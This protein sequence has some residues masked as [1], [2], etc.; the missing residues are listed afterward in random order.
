MAQIEDVLKALRAAD[1]AGNTEDAARL[2]QLAQ[3]MRS[4][5]AVPALA[6]PKESAVPVEPVAPGAQR[7]PANPDQM[8]PVPSIP[9][10]ADALARAMSE[11]PITPLDGRIGL[12]TDGGA[13]WAREEAAKRA[14]AETAPPMS[15]PKPPVAPTA[16]PLAANPMRGPV[17]EELGRSNPGSLS[18]QAAAA[19]I[20][21]EAMDPTTKSTF[22][23]T[24]Q[25]YTPTGEAILSELGNSWSRI[26]RGFL[27]NRLA[28]AE[29]GIAAGVTDIGR[30]KD[31]ATDPVAALTAVQN[32][33]AEAEL[34]FQGTADPVE[35]Q[36]ILAEIR[37][38]GQEEDRL[39]T[40]VTVP[41]MAGR[42]VETNQGQLEWNQRRRAETQAKIDDLE[43]AMTPVNPAPGL[44]Q[45]LVSGIA[46]VGDMAPGM[47]ATLATRNPLPMLTYL[48]AYSRG[49]T[50]VDKRAEG[51]DSGKAVTAANL[52]AV[53]EAVPELLPLHVILKE[54]GG[55]LSKIVGGA[56]TEAASEVLT[57][58]LQQLVDMGV[59][60]ESMTWA[61]AQQ[62]MIDSGMA[63]GVMGALMGGGGA[64]AES[65]RDTVAS[66]RAKKG[67]PADPTATGPAPA[68]KAQDAPPA[69]P[70][71]SLT[72]NMRADAP[73]EADVAPVTPG[74]DAPVSTPP[75]PLQPE[76]DR[77]QTGVGSEL[78]GATAAPKARPDAPA[79]GAT[80]SATD[81]EA[82]PDRYEIMDEIEGVGPGA[83]P[84]GRRVARDRETGAFLVVDEIPAGPTAGDPPG[85]S[86]PAG[87]SSQVAPSVVAG[88]AGGAPAD[89]DPL[90]PESQIAAAMAPETAPPERPANQ[91][92]NVEFIDSRGVAQIGTEPGVMQYKA[93]GDAE[94]VTDRLRGVTEW[95]PERAGMSIVYEYADGRRVI[96]DGHQRLGLAKRLAGEG[97]QV[98]MPA[99]ILRQR[100]GITPE[101]ARVTAALKN[102]AE[103]SGTAVDAA[104]VLRGSNQTAE[105]MGLP[106]NSAIVRDA[107]GMRNL[108]D[109]A[110]GMVV[111]GVSSERDGGIVGRI[112]QNKEAQANI[113]ALLNR[114]KPSN[115]F[116]AESIARQAAADVVTETQD[117]LFGPEMDTRNLY[118]ERAKILDG[119]A[120]LNRDE[121]RAFGTVVQNA[122]RLQ[123]AGNVLD[124]ASNQSRM[125]SASAMRDYLTKEA[126]TRGPIS[127]ALT[128]AARALSG[129]A[130][131]GEATRQF[132]AAVERGLGSGGQDSPVRN[133]GGRQTE[134]LG[135]KG[136]KPESL[137][138]EEQI[139]AAIAPPKSS[140]NPKQAR[141]EA[142]AAVKG[143]QSKIRTSAPQGDPG[144]LFDDQGDLLGVARFQRQPDLVQDEDATPAYAVRDRIPEEG[145]LGGSNLA[146]ADDQQELND[147]NK[148]SGR[149]PLYDRQEQVAAAL[150]Y[151]PSGSA[152]VR[153]ADEATGRIVKLLPRLRAEL[154][155]LDL[156]RVR[157]GVETGVDWQG[158]FAITGDGAME[159][160]IGAS[161]DPM[162]TLHH[163]VIHA[164]RM[165]DLFTPAEWKVLE[166]A[167]ETW[168]EKHDIAARY[169]DLSHAEQ[170][171]EAIA[172]EFSE[173]LAAKKAPRGSLLIQAF[174]KIARV[175]RAIANV[176]RGAGFHS[177]EDIFGRVLAGE[178]GARAGTAG[179]GG[180][181]L[182]DVAAYQK[183]QGIGASLDAEMDPVAVDASSI[184][185]GTEKATARDAVAR[186][187]GKTLATADGTAVRI[188]KNTQGK[189]GAFPKGDWRA[190]AAVA[191]AL[192]RIITAARVF[193]TSQDE[194]GR[195]VG[196]K[197]AAAVA[198]IDGE[199]VVVRLS[200]MHD[201]SRPDQS[202]AYDLQG[203]EIERLPASNAGAEGTS[204]DPLPGNRVITLGEAVAAIKRG[205]RRF[206]RPRI[207]SRQARAHMSTAMGGEAA[208]VPDRRI[209]EELSSV[210]ASVWNRIGG[211]AGAVS[212]T[213]DRARVGLQDR[214]LPIMRAQEVLERANGKPLPLDQRA[215]LAETTFSGKAGRH[216]FEIDEEFTKP[217]INLIAKTEGLN[218]EIV[219][220]WLYARHAIE[221][222]ARIASINPKMPDG[223][224]G[225]TNAEAQQI[226][227]DSKKGPQ[228]DVLDAIGEKIDQL[229]ERMLKLRENAGLITAEEAATWRNSYA[230]Y[231]PLKGFSE[232]EH[233]DAA[234]DVSGAG[235]RFI[236]RGDESRRALGRRSEAFNPLQAALTQA[237]EVAIR[238]EKNRVAQSVYELA[239]ANPSPALWE[240]KKPA[241]KRY[242]N[243]T[244]GMVE[245]R[246]ENPISFN[247][248]PN[249]MAAKV[250]GEEVRIIFHDPRLA[251]AVIGLGA[252]QWQGIVKTI[253]PFARLFSMVNTGLSPAFVIKNAIR[254][255]TT[256][257]LNMAALHE[258]KAAGF[259][260]TKTQRAKIMLAMAKNWRKALL[261]TFRGQGYRFDTKWS[262]Y[263]EEFQKAGAQVWFFQVEDPQAGKADLDKR[264]RLAR[265]NLAVR[266]LKRM[267]PN[268]FFSARDNHV[269]HFIERVNLAVDNAI[270]LA[271]FVE[272]R[273]QGLSQDQ[274]A[275]LA[276][277]LTT[278]FNR[279]GKYGA[280]LNAIFP[281]FNA[282]M[283]GNFRLFQAFR[284][285]KVLIGETVGFLVFGAIM[286]IINAALSEEDDDGE[287][288]YD[289]IPDYRNRTNLHLMW[290]TGNDHAAWSMPLA[291]GYN[292]FFYAGQQIGKVW[293]GVKPA[294]EAF[295]DV[296]VSVAESYMPTDTLVPTI[297]APAW[298]LRANENAFGSAI[299]PEDLFGD[300]RYLADAEKYF[301]SASEASK[302]IAKSMNE[303]T[304]GSP[305]EP[306][307]IDVS[308]ETIDHYLAF[309]T[310]GAGRFWGNGFDNLAKVLQGKTDE[311]ETKKIPFV[312]VFLSEV[313]PWADNDRYRKFG[314][315]VRDAKA[316][317]DN[318]AEHGLSDGDLRPDVRKLSNLYD[319]LLRAEREMKGQ[320]EFNPNSKSSKYKFERLPRDERTIK[321]EFNRRF[322][323]VAGP[324][325]E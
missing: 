154:D 93:G 164:L 178:I 237:Q 18:D 54:G 252:D 17:F 86:P 170:I 251:D 191:S 95:R 249:E 161:L 182:G 207:P 304:G 101:Q 221:R 83:R 137:T 122:D 257:Q 298:E 308:P 281:F 115:A 165:M 179:R 141:A 293:R 279:R 126:N 194:G 72:P 173:A 172:E 74:P 238:A 242:F 240:V 42:A 80:I 241:Q 278:N 69:P 31:V 184:E 156:K 64:L 145:R 275:F 262:K 9:S 325:A 272:A 181:S 114:L 285:W 265:G 322:L 13:A 125:D 192:D 282:A 55:A 313:S 206:A 32:R 168:I 147:S 215:Y 94:G 261:G 19:R 35:R 269:L 96:A 5:P 175:F 22:T 38:L 7:F 47:V 258:N 106:P 27:G 152:V 102:I 243:R 314:T 81:A 203:F 300:N 247:L 56:A 34:R 231:V 129:G 40:L 148:D 146:P 244:T 14:A 239:K 209:W 310:G 301:P 88:P 214:F 75:A 77:S 169:P 37:Q 118:L 233:S 48:G 155:R 273:E 119:A 317:I 195:T 212:D 61:Q 226:L 2:A 210:Q 177:A 24:P 232:T 213:V 305:L 324:R 82:A 176:L 316:D 263:F 250:A 217:I 218:A 189:V 128:A 117:S 123:A 229:R 309:V 180:R 133:S 143:N 280:A 277:E 185:P 311:I 236:T 132:L 274:A 70:P 171:E 10:P 227:N 299:Y 320:G 65:M 201:N 283:Q 319:L 271:A 79:P 287:L 196:W 139:A 202:M 33:K 246:V 253:G 112:V 264:I 188:T 25:D 234:L 222:N 63:G 219:G 294:D 136:A 16:P 20:I 84:T 135:G 68:P 78:E 43:A 296:L 109:Q 142:E 104:K 167:G 110:F 199:A 140:K 160:V 291:Y 8:G 312:N 60:D 87:E 41:G 57:Q 224:S 39:S 124:A 197:Y 67:T 230:H 205:V 174:N 288:I 159:I 12:A 150:G 208:F 71:L 276:K 256:A 36:Q 130:K 228:S 1:A 3:Q 121:M 235:R 187:R 103:G 134:R 144:P 52:Y 284:N 113:L 245:T 254:D 26:K 73:A 290:M 193:E 105:Q 50:Y 111:N 15:T 318:M 127:D 266:S 58:G 190:R 100:D 267:S 248:N 204:A 85:S 51:Y 303:A 98:Q 92:G 49:S 297:L 116:Q 306:G 4:T 163:E 107:M 91:P 46:S 162:K 158:A 59:L 286:D 120:K 76:P 225:M 186:M 200:L 138:P 211:A 153:D 11:A 21:A 268:A 99:I 289:K 220:R 198:K 53:A 166:L 97:K 270:R 90:T 255:F 108:S 259:A 151:Y 295:A 23:P 28:E 223:G 321:M 131:P 66:R 89:S 44:P 149:Q 302:L 45:A 292:T 260:L 323:E 30:A 216:L 157:L 6:D 183:G 315:E 29:S 307:L 62:E